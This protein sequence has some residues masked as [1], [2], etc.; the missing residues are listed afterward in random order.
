MPLKVNSDSERVI[1]VVRKTLLFL[2]K[3][4]TVVVVFV[5]QGERRADK[6]KK[7]NRGELFI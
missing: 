5:R 2:R 1:E 6:E 3:S 4:Y 7:T